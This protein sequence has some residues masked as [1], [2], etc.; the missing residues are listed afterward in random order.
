[1]MVS[2]VLSVP[3]GSMQ[4]KGYGLSEALPLNRPIQCD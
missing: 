4:V 2:W 1:M 3:L